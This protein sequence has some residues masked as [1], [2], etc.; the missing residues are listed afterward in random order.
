MRQIARDSWPCL[1]QRPRTFSNYV[2]VRTYS[3]CTF[4]T[5]IIVVTATVSKYTVYCSDVCV[6]AIHHHFIPQSHSTPVFGSD[7][8][9][10]RGRTGSDSLNPGEN[11]ITFELQ[12]STSVHFR[13]DGIL[14]EHFNSI[15]R[16]ES[17]LQC[18][19][20]SSVVEPPSHSESFGHSEL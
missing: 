13:T 4:C 14:L 19:C 8:R 17:S 11:C 6:P 9:S 7:P 2:H 3:N 15:P 5:C 12:Y 10:D 1:W 20:R 16:C 18:T